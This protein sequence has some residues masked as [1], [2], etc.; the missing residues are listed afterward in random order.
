MLVLKSE[1]T[2]M[3]DEQ[4]QS[5]NDS[6]ATMKNFGLIKESSYVFNCYFASNLDSNI[7]AQQLDQQNFH[8]F[9]L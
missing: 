7:D 8:W 4:V 2:L 1:P 9:N 3:P 5:N 6:T